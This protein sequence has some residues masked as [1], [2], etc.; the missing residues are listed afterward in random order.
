MI[1]FAGKSVLITGAAGGIG[2][3]AALRFAQGGANVALSDINASALQN[4]H[5]EVAGI[6]GQVISVQT[7]ISDAASC[8]DT[9]EQARARFGSVDHLVHCAGV[10]PEVMVADMT[11]DEWHRL[12]RINLDGTFHI[13]RAAIPVLSANSS[14][15]NLSSISAHRG[16]YAHAHYS[17]SKG[18]VSSF[19]KSLALELAPATRVNIV[20]PG[21]IDTAMTERLREQKGQALLD[22]T[23]LKRFGTPDDVAGV[24]VFLCSDLAS[25]MTGETVHVN[26]GLY[27]V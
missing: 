17:A 5:D 21:I 24:I 20:A 3:A 9:V 6:G 16:S 10:Y 13:C 15:V 27:I 23:L 14:I 22:N 12:M 8:K 11:D 18:A 4:V 19:S 1:S 2:R 26:G 25:F 7:D